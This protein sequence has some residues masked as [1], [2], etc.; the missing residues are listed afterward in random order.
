MARRRL[1][2]S[3]CSG[4]IKQKEEA[5]DMSSIAI[6]SVVFVFVFGSALLGSW[7]R[8]RLPEHHRDENSLRAVS[9]GVGMVATLAALVLGLLTASGKSS[10][11]KLNDEFTRIAASVVLLDR[12]LAN[13]GPEAGELRVQLRDDY[14]NA[15]ELIFKEGDRALAKLDRPGKLASAE[16]LQGRIRALAP[17]NEGQR[18]LQSRALELSNELS[19]I[20]M[21][22]IAHGT[23]AIPPLFLVILVFWLSIIFAGYGLLTANN[24][25][26]AATLLVCALCVSG[27]IFLVEEMAR[28]F[29][30]ML[31]ISSAAQHAALAR[32]GK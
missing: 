31:R 10:L 17:Q 30:G 20:R 16:A 11:D 5:G 6:A 25:T 23:S 9:L 19:Q 22:A 13:F 1:H 4:N 18:W 15:I 3:A 32:L 26:V 7:V 21:L 8:E 24:G 27:S 29:D 12:A 14:A 2:G 28:P